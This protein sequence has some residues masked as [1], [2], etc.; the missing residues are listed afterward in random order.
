MWGEAGVAFGEMARSAAKDQRSSANP[1]I[2]SEEYQ[3]PWHSSTSE[4]FLCRFLIGAAFWSHPLSSMFPGW[5]LG[6]PMSNNVVNIVAIPIEKPV[7]REPQHML[8]DGAF[9]SFSITQ[10]TS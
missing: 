8:S 3:I 7:S 4:V 1:V 9:A 2:S 6:L 5:L 10:T